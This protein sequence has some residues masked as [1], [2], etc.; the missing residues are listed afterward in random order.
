MFSEQEGHAKL[1]V[2]A[3]PPPSEALKGQ[4]EDMGLQ[5]E[6]S[7]RLLEQQRQLKAK[8]RMEKAAKQAAKGR[9]RGCLNSSVYLLIMT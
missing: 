4:L 2:D 1:A 7:V 8:G 5:V 9:G 3:I 6:D